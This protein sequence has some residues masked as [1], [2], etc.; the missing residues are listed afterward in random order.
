MQL[1]FDWSAWIFGFIGAIGGLMVLSGL[2]SGSKTTSNTVEH[3]NLNRQSGGPGD[4]VNKVKHGDDNIQ[5][6]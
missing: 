3:G 2:R 6:G 5:K 4:T 1:F